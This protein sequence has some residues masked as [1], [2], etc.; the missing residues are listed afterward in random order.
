MLPLIAPIREAVEC[1][2]AVQPVGAGLL[3]PVRPDG[4]RNRPRGGHDERP[5][6]ARRDGLDRLGQCWD[7][8]CARDAGNV[9]EG[10]VVEAKKAVE[11]Q[12]GA[13][14]TALWQRRGSKMLIDATIPPPADFAL[15]SEIRE[16]SRPRGRML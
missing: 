4:Q 14:G 12:L 1:A 6:S 3:G 11:Q 15:L 16:R 2:V 10:C 7:D 8:R 5:I 9:G 13:P